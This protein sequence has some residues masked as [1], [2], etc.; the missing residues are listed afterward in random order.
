LTDYYPFLYILRSIISI[1]ITT[2][3]EYFDNLAKELGIRSFSDWFA[4]EKQQVLKNNKAASIVSGYYGGSLTK[5]IQTLYHDE[6]TDIKVI[7]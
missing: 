5:A 3:K 6:V 4:L 7:P 2:Q 1:T